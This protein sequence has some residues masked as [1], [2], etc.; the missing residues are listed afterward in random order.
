M[1]EV[2]L[3]MVFSLVFTLIEPLRAAPGNGAEGPTER[4]GPLAPGKDPLRQVGN[5][6]S[7]LQKALAGGLLLR[8]AVALAEERAAAE[9]A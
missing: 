6:S 5:A 8:R 3:F 7:D 1:E 9:R 4:A 2:T